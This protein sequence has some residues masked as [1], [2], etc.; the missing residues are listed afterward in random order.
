[1][2]KR[3]CVVALL[4]V[5]VVLVTACGLVRGAATPMPIPPTAT[6]P[7]V[8]ARPATATTGPSTATPVPPTVSPAAA[9][10]TLEPTTA[11]AT[12]TPVTTP[13]PKP[14]AGARI[15][16]SEVSIAE[17]SPGVVHVAGKA[18]V[19]E[20]TLTIA[21]VDASGD[22]IASGA[23]HASMGAPEWGDFAIDFYYPPPAAAQQVTLEAYEPSPK[24]GSPSGLVER[25]VV[26]QPVPDL[27][28]W[29]SFDNA[30]YHFTARYPSTWYLN[31]GSMMPAPPLATKLS[32]YQTRTPGQPLGEDQ[33][34]IWI[35]VSDVPS[36]AEMDYLE[37]K[38]YQETA[39]V[40]G[41]RQGVRYTAPEPGHGV[42]DVIYTLSGPREYRLQLSAATHNFDS[43]F[44][45]VLATFGVAE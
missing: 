2:K 19:F 14:T 36:V 42:Y 4:S 26:L 31:Q 28:S 15:V 35:T 13:G 6:Q 11:P 16:L 44:T 38:G 27:A 45:L 23:A 32:T 34:E 12:A 25:D 10:V 24:D 21:L 22:V 1:M 17:S 43:I 3:L 30:T 20:A 37:A 33:A 41:G 8:T 40:V 5:S 9:T 29:K 18:Q 7:P 39:V